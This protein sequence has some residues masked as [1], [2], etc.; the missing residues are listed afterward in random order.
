MVNKQNLNKEIS[1]WLSSANSFENVAKN[2]Q[3]SA[4]NDHGLLIASAVNASL[5]LE[6]FVKTLVLLEGKNYEK[7]HDLNKN[8][9][10][11]S[12]QTKMLL[13]KSFEEQLTDELLSQIKILSDESGITIE[14]KLDDTLK[15]WS[16]VFVN[17][18]Y[19]FA[20]K[21]EGFHWYFFEELLQALKI[22]IYELRKNINEH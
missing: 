11:L 8:F 12:K 15:N 6:C 16:K 21:H 3:V 5:A 20:I 14:P 19:W 17:G 22:T 1:G 2:I 10:L 9:N 4:G 13:E 7:T 18:R